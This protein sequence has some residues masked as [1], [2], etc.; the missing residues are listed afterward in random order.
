MK[1]YHGVPSPRKMA[2]AREVA[3]NIEQGA[4]WLPHRMTDHGWDW[5][6]DNGAYSAP[7]DP[8]EWLKGLRRANRKM[9]ND[10]DFAVLPDV[11]GEWE[12]TKRLH[13][14]YACYADAMGWETATVAQPGGTVEEIVE[15]A[16]D[17]GSSTIFIGGGEAHIR[18]RAA[19]LTAAA[20]DAGLRAH[21]GRPGESLSWARDHGVDSVDTTA[22]M[23]NQ[24]WHRL[25]KLEGAE[26][27]METTLV[28]EWG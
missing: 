13:E 22:I 5:I 7:F 28:D 23:R 17:Q 19:E 27:T 9:S 15:F 6:L 2:K 3:P 8:D 14:R 4:E 1:V 10:P 26:P 20:H 21:I 18:R 16:L 25:R 12:G 24:L 11:F